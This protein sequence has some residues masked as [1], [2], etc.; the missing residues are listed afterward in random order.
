MRPGKHNASRR[1]TER[2]TDIR[3]RLRRGLRTIRRRGCPE[4]CGGVRGRVPLVRH[5]VVHGLRTCRKTGVRVCRR[6]AGIDHIRTAASQSVAVYLADCGPREYDYAGSTCTGRRCDIRAP[7]LCIEIA[8]IR[9]VLLCTDYIPVIEH[10]R[11]EQAQR[12]YDDLGFPNNSRS[13]F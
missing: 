9:I 13:F 10:R 12:Q 2:R 7:D 1:L 6:R 8:L 11:N 3:R 5:K 4:C